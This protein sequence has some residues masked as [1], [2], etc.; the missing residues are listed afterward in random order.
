M[1]GSLMQK[2]ELVTVLSESAGRGVNC[3]LVD[4][5]HTNRKIWVRFPTNQVLEMTWNA[6]RRV[7]EGRMAKMDFRVEA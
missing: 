5:D 1:D 3:V 7:Y 4:I 2:G 6:R